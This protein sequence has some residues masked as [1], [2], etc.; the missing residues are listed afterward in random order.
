MFYIWVESQI[1]PDFNGWDAPS[2]GWM[3]KSVIS[4]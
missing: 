4:V 3:H 1:K 2:E